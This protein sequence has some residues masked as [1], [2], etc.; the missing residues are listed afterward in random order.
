MAGQIPEE[1]K[2][3]RRAQLM[4]LQQEIAFD[5]AVCLSASGSINFPKF[6]TRLYFL[7][8]LPSNKSVRLATMKIANAIHLSVDYLVKNK[9]IMKET[10]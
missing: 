8:I 5:A 6:V 2:E 3:E 9:D 7:A 1:V 10:K 4:E